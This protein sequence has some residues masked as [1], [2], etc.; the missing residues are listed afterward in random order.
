MTRG[1]T[2]GSTVNVR[3]PFWGGRDFLAKRQSVRRT[4][5]KI[6]PPE[7]RDAFKLYGRRASGI[8][9]NKK[10]TGFLRRRRRAREEN[11]WFSITPRGI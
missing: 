3:S 6:S 1:Y 9:V 2:N 10:T 4:G 7:C 8:D 5:A 11:L